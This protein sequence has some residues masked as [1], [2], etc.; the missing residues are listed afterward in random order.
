MQVKGNSAVLLKT[1]NHGSITIDASISVDGL[2]D[3]TAGP[4]G[5]KGGAIGLNGEGPGGGTN[6]LGSGGSYG[7]P[8]EGEALP[9]LYGDARLASLIGGSGGRGLSTS[10]GGG[11][12]GAFGLEANGTGDITIGS[13]G[14]LSA[15]GAGSA[16]GAGAGGAIYLKGD[17]ITNNGVI[18]ATGGVSTSA[19]PADGGGG[20]VAIHTVKSAIFGTVNVGNGSISVVGD[21]GYKDSRVCGRYAC[22]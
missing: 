19:S 5:F 15:R 21:M 12:A 10:G 6:T 16:A 7:G 2:T 18:R 11:G 13:T 22:I 17:V 14:V 9:V 8:G 3:G 20:R 4:G 1:R